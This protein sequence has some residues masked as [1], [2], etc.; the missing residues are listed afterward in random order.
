MIL[1]TNVLPQKK[2][3]KYL[4]NLVKFSSLLYW[5]SWH[6]SFQLLL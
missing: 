2:P 4:R 1:N 6:S 3:I 5:S